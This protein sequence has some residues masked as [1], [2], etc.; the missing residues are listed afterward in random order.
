MKKGDMLTRIDTS[1]ILRNAA[2]ANVKI[3]GASRKCTEACS[4]FEIS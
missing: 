1:A 3:G 2:T 4:W